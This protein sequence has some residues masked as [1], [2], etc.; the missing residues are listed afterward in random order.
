[1]SGRLK[2]AARSGD[3][4]TLKSLLSSQPP[5][6]DHAA[7]LG[8][9]LLLAAGNG[10]QHIISYLI[11]EENVDVNFLSDYNSGNKSALMK[12]IESK[13]VGAVKQ[14]VNDYSA[15]VDL[16]NSQKEFALQMACKQGDLEIVEVLL[17]KGCSINNKDS[18][19]SPLEIA[20]END[21]V[22][23][24]LSLVK[25]GAKMIGRSKS[26]LCIACDNGNYNMV[27]VLLENG[28]AAHVNYCHNPGDRSALMRAS[29]RGH[30]KIIKLLLEYGA[31]INA[32]DEEGGSPLLYAIQYKH[33]ETV[34]LLVKNGANVNQR[35]RIEG[36][37]E[38]TPL[39]LALRKAE[40]LNPNYGANQER[41]PDKFIAIVTA[42]LSGD[43]DVNMQDKNGKAALSYAIQS[44]SVKIIELL[45]DAGADID[46]NTPLMSAVQSRHYGI[47]QLLLK[48]KANVNFQD[49]ESMRT[50]LMI[51]ANYGDLKIV[52][53]L[54]KHGADVDLRDGEGYY[55]L[56]TAVERQHYNVS[57]LLLKKKAKS[58]LIRDRDGKS[59][60]I[61]LKENY[62]REVR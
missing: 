44:G 20:V 21:H 59:A 27:K 60:A 15:D 42:L 1:M 4:E 3:L 46:Q 48:R 49:G 41:N 50:P 19:N 40:I 25:K 22:E 55:A 16:V 37:M 14:L 28:G 17:S 30:N 7:T 39:M 47:V 45:L 52:D 62:A 51:A 61:I 53:L 6:G 8:T 43:A 11:E 23:V 58:D 18:W 38:A 10:H 57:R 5:S 32:V 12:A 13:Q 9:L 24:A 2:Q 56:L 33:P 35:H 26:V 36:M 34:S 29:F 31:D 54:I